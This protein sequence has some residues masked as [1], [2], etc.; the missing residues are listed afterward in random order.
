MSSPAD[1]PGAALLIVDVQVG[2]MDP[3]IRRDGV[4]ANVASLVDRARGAAAPVVWVMHGDDELRRD[5]DAWQLVPELVVGDGERVVHKTHGDSFEA[6][7]LDDVLADLDVGRLVVAGAQSDACITSTL[8]GAAARGYGVMLVS[9]AHTTE[10][11]TEWGGA[12]PAAVISH[13]NLMWGM[14]TVEGRATGTV[15]TAE[16]A[17]G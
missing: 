7:D 14:H 8:H 17:F 4:V 16:A 5:S 13:T 10:D 1:R 15:T 11:L 12:D 9:D 2:V 6:T 3:S